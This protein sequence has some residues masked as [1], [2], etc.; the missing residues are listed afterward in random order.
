MGSKHNISNAYKN[1]HGSTLS[2]FV[3][4]WYQT[5]WPVPFTFTSMGQFTIVHMPVKYIIGRWI[6][7]NR[8]YNHIKTKH[9][10]TT[11][12]W[13]HNGRWRLKSPTSSVFT[14][15]FIQAQIKEDIKAPC[16]WPLC[17]EF[18]GDRS[19]PCTKGQERGKWFHLMTS[20]WCAYFMWPKARETAVLGEEH[21]TTGAC[22][23]RRSWSTHTILRYY[24]CS[25]RPFQ[26]S[27]QQLGWSN[28]NS[29]F[30]EYFYML[31]VASWCIC[32]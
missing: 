17:G 6:H 16:H 18:T 8:W 4:V 21:A 1:G 23:S 2:C 25:Q 9:I 24:K 12:Q 28:E 7:G 29:P 31:C 26:P 5:I 22:C 11:L 27:D 20:S 14:Q 3:E 32:Q 10:K 15:P 19:I 30:Y 13:R